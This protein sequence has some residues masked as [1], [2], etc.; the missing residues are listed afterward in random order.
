MPVSFLKFFLYFACPLMVLSCQPQPPAPVDQSS[1]E[2]E[3]DDRRDRGRYNRGDRGRYSRTRGGDDNR[4]RRH[5]CRNY[6]EQSDYICNE[7]DDCIDA[8]DE[9]F[10]I[11]KYEAEC[12]KLPAE[13]VYDI[14][15][16]LLQIDDGDAGD[17]DPGALHCLLNITD[18]QFLDELDGLSVREAKDLLQQIASD[19]DLAETLSGHDE[20]YTILNTVMDAAF[21]D[22]GLPALRESLARDS[23]T[24]FDLILNCMLK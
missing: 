12:L 14:E 3:D 19:E 21:G 18:Q 16:L 6:G 10:P 24:F 8:C 9:L 5:S 22:T 7:D 15:A 13:L 23:V 4:T 20:N 2:E 17:I 1:E 11:R